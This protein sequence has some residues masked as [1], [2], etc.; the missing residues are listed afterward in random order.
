MSTDR[1]RLC[2]LLVNL[3]PKSHLDPTN[4]GPIHIDNPGQRIICGGRTLLSS[5]GLRR[6]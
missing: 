6:S 1:V 3:Q 4:R 2:F 5:N